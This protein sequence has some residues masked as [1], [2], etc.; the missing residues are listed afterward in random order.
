MNKKAKKEL[1]KFKETNLLIERCLKLLA[2]CNMDITKICLDVVRGTERLLEA[3]IPDAK[4]ML[5]QQGALE[6]CKIISAV[7][8]K[9]SDEYKKESEILKG[10]ANG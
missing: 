9:C 7:L 2:K 4:S 6:L 3:D 5:M 1:D 8:N 10:L